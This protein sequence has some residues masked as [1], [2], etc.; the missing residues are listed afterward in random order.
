MDIHFWI[1]T[2]QL[3]RNSRRL[4]YISDSYIF[5]CWIYWVRKTIDFGYHFWL[6]FQILSFLNAIQCC[7]VLYCTVMM[8]HSSFPLCC[9]NKIIIH[10][11]R[12]RMFLWNPEYTWW[13]VFEWKT[14]KRLFPAKSSI[15]LCDLRKLVECCAH[16]IHIH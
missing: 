8:T 3:R 1:Y 2:V 6:A 15:E 9:F 7:T 16:A 14:P 13:N 5:L 10:S 11:V 12:F 4:V